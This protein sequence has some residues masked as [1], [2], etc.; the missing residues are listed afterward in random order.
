MKPLPGYLRGQ[1]IG[2]QYGQKTLGVAGSP[3]DFLIFESSG[4][5]DQSLFITPGPGHNVILI[6]LGLVD[7][8]L[9]ISQ[10][11][12]HLLEGISDLFGRIG[13]LETD[14]SD[15]DAAPVIFQQA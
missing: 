10:S 14:V 6:G 8:A 4:F 13:D 1:A 7:E 9:S 2:L 12:N 5:L 11:P 15:L 3:E